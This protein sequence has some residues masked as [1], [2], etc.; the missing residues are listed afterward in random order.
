MQKS[1][2]GT[3]ALILTAVLGILT[4]ITSLDA[5][6]TEAEGR[7]LADLQ[8]QAC[9]ARALIF[10]AQLACA[11]I[12]PDT[13]WAVHRLPIPGFFGLIT[14][15]TLGFGVAMLAKPDEDS[16]A[17]MASTEERE[18]QRKLALAAQEKMREEQSKREGTS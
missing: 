5:R 8:R 9:N 10:E 16:P 6:L 12:E 17:D 14:W 3:T 13:G 4:A 7:A 1:T 18:R 15:L 2:I 11:R